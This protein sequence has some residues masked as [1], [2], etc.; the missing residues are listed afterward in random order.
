VAPT[1]QAISFV[2]LG[3]PR[4]QPELPNRDEDSAAHQGID[5][6]QDIHVTCF[7]KGGMRI[8]HLSMLLHSDENAKIQGVWG[9]KKS[10]NNFKPSYDAET[11]SLHMPQ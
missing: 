4:H 7:Q 8:I 1:F 2:C 11:H 5:V 10:N 3:K 6:K 9:P